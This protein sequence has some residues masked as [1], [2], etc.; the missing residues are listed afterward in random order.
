MSDLI[1]D[2]RTAGATIADVAGDLVV[3]MCKADAPVSQASATNPAPGRLRDDIR[4]LDRLSGDVEMR[5]V[6][7]DLVYAGFTDEV[8]TAPH[9]IEAT[10]SPLLR[11]HWDRGPSGPGVYFFRFVN[12][13]GTTGRRWFAS[14]MDDRWV[15][16]LDTANA[17]YTS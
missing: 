17:G 1:A 16:A 15:S 11:F 10:N 12:H 13:P 8:D 6:G 7:S 14:K 4:I 3:D 2:V 9:R 5:A